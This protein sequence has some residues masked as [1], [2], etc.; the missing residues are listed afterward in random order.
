MNKEEEIREQIRKIHEP[1]VS[2]VKLRYADGRE[3]TVEVRELRAMPYKVR[4][5][6]GVRDF[7]TSFI[8]PIKNYLARRRWRK[9]GSPVF[10]YP[11]YNCGCCG[12]YIK[13]EIEV[14]TYESLGSWDTWGL[15]P[16]GPEACYN[17]EEVK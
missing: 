4:W 7:F 5:Y 12:K 10:V 16:E 14:P 1:I 3:E 13:E 17:K 2:K 6:H 9:S 11:G 8:R 15:C